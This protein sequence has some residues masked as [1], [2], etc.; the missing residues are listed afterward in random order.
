MEE[1]LKRELKDKI[2]EQVEKTF[3]VMF[4]AKV[5]S[6]DNK[7]SAFNDDDLITKAVMH[8]DNLE[9]ILRFVFPRHLLK[10]LLL[11]VY[12]PELATHEMAYEDA[13]CEITNIVCSGLKTYL[14]ESNY[15][16]VMNLPAVDYGFVDTNVTHKANEHLNLHFMLQD[17]NFL[18]DLIMDNKAK[19]SL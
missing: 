7:H 4:S 19:N 11:K 14:N 13:A 1:K 12:P 15:K 2:T 16:L 18:V 8:Q 17:S 10:P 9:V 3:A 5:Q 6:V